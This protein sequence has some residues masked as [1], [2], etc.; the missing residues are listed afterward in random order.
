[1]ASHTPWKTRSSSG[2]ATTPQSDAVVCKLGR[3]WG[4]LQFRSSTR[5]ERSHRQ[6]GRATPGTAPGGRAHL[7]NLVLRVHGAGPAAACGHRSSTM[8]SR[9]CEQQ[10]NTLPSAGG[11]T[12]S[13]L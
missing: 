5:T 4:T 9:G 2:V 10:M 11:S 3:P 13:G 12:G 8:S 6:R 1:M 7:D